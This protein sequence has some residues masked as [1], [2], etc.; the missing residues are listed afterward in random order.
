MPT[1]TSVNPYDPTDVVLETVCV[2]PEHVPALTQRAQAGFREW[3]S[4]PSPQRQDD[5]SIVLS[6]A[7]QDRAANLI[8]YAAVGH[9]GQKC[10]ATRR[11]IVQRRILDDFRKQFVDAVSGVIVGAPADEQT[12]VGPVISEEA[13]STALAAVTDS[14]GEVLGGGRAVKG[15]PGFYVDATIV[16]VAEASDRLAC[17]EVFSPVVALMA[18]EDAEEALHHAPFGGLGPREQGLAT[19]ILHRDPNTPC[20]AATAPLRVT[21]RPSARAGTRG[22]HDED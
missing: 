21:A 5:A 8:A 9:A 4:R 1:I 20:G 13:R 12:V 10:T 15:R 16:E 7:D 2:D 17:D 6:D 3:N 14:R 22:D 19:G 18:A 11:V